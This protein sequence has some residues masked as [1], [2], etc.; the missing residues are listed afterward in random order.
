MAGNNDELKLQA[1]NRKNDYKSGS[2]SSQLHDLT[3][4]DD[5]GNELSFMTPS[6]KISS[7][8]SILK[9]YPDSPL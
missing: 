5:R 3:P 4:S 1:L 6:R 9:L 2:A 8:R 7:Y